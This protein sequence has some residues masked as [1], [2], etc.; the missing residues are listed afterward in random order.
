MAVDGSPGPFSPG[1]VLQLF[2]DSGALSGI[3]NSST[4]KEVGVGVLNGYSYMLVF[5]SRAAGMCYL[6]FF[7]P[8]PFPSSLITSLLSYLF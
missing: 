3:F 4:Y 2:V 8:T 6:F 1:A 7:V 5:A